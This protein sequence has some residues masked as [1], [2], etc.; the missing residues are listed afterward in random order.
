MEQGR[1]S[2]TLVSREQTGPAPAALSRA[3]FNTP[4]G[5]VIME[6]IPDRSG[7]TPVLTPIMP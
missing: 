6:I 7:L 3:F 4:V 2:T 5:R 1:Q